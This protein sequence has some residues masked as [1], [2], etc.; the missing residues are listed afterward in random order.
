V[1]KAEA[2]KK[3]R[4][5]QRANETVRQRAEKGQQLKPHRLRRLGVI[6]KPFRPL[7]KLKTLPIWGPFKFAG[8]W[9]AKLLVPPYL[10]SSFKELRQVTWP[11]RAQTFKLTSAVLIFALVFGIIVAIVD[12]GLDKLFKQVILR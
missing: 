11:N 3:T 8:R 6:A 9:L 12:F 4:R 5:L 7:G 10:R 1:A 2:E